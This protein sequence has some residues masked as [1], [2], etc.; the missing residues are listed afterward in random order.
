MQAI[1]AKLFAAG[2]D[3]VVLIGG[4]LPALPFS[5]LDEAYAFLQ[6]KDRGVVLGPAADGGYYLV[7]CNRP[8]PEIF[9]KMKWSHGA[10]LAQTRARLS[11]L[12]IDHRLLPG[13][14]DLDTA[15]DLAALRAVLESSVGAAMPHTAN[16]LQRL[17]LKNG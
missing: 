17:S 4:D 7:G 1:F 3:A 13:W 5:A 10:V 8:T 9:R 14:F 2:H 16:L 15:E 12:D 6:S 11:M